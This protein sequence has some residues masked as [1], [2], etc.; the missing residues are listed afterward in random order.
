MKIYAILIGIIVVLITALSILFYSYQSKSDQ[1]DRANN[2][3]SILTDTITHFTDKTG[4]QALRIG[5]LQL[6]KQEVEH[7]KDSIIRKLYQENLNMGNKLHRT[8]QLLNIK[9]VIHDTTILLIN[10]TTIIRVN[11]TITKIA[12]HTDKWIDLTLNILDNHIEMDYTFRDDL[13][14]SIGWHRKKLKFPPWNWF[15]FGKK[16]Y[17]ADI[18]SMNPNSHIQYSKN[19]RITGKRGK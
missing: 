6:T 8:E 12:T 14:I 1:L 18:K 15:G 4:A 19:V 5:E 17:D 3:I 13:I 9:T 11:D 2:N 16:I 10:D 7:S